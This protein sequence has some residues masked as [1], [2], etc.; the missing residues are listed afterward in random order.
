MTL[1]A[2]IAGVAIYFLY[3]LRQAVDTTVRAE[4]T[5]AADNAL[6]RIGREV[7]LALPN[8]V[9]TDAS[10]RFLEFLPVRTAGRYRSESSGAGCG[11]DTDELAFDAP[12]TCFKT[13]GAL[14]NA[15]TVTTNDFL[16]LNNYGP[17]F[18]GQDA[19]EAAGTNRVKLTLAADEGTHERLEFASKTFSR[20]LHDS[21]GHRFFVVNGNATTSLPEPVT[22]DC[23]GS[24]LVRR[25]GYALSASQPTSFSSGSSALLT[26]DVGTCRFDYEPNTAPQVGLLTLRLTLSRTLSGGATESVTLFHS[27]HVTNVP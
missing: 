16:V 10:H 2:I 6:Q 14:A 25:W 11:G 15:A 27:I 24:A 7:R 9:R 3:P 22:F 13:I 20:A 17:G 12:E 26:N 8:S 19:Y 5:D 1:V 18:T 4:L 21:P 23:S